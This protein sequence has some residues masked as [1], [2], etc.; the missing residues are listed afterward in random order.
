M[1]SYSWKATCCGDHASVYRAVK[2]FDLAPS[3]LCPH[4]G[5]KDVGCMVRQ[6]AT[7]QRV[8]YCNE[9]TGGTWDEQ[10]ECGRGQWERI[11]CAPVNRWRF[12]D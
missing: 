4:C 8:Y 1:P 5:G 3:R 9:C 7:Q 6:D 12:C 2:Y 10:C 11:V